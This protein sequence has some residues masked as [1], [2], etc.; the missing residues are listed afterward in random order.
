MF[1]FLFSGLCKVCNQHLNLINISDEEFD[2][3]RTQF[4][5][6]VVI[7]ENIFTKSTPAEVAGFINYVRNTSPYD[8]VIDGLNVAYMKNIRHPT[9]NNLRLMDFSLVSI[10]FDLKIVN[11][12][13]LRLVLACNNIFNYYYRLMIKK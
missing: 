5:E 10:I 9:M 13:N 7:G 4:L 11:I 6:K 8:I 1:F 2:R 12:Y 3:L